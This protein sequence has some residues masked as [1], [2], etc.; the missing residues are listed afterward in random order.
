M[1]NNEI[2]SIL[3]KL[4]K[5]EITD[6]QAEVMIKKIVDKSTK[7]TSLDSGASCRY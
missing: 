2:M 5:G 4:K 1:A 7:K 6:I 3:R